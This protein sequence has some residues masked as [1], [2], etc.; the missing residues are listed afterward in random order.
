MYYFLFHW[1][2][3]S[4]LHF[5]P[6]TQPYFLLTLGGF[7][8]IPNIPTNTFTNLC[9]SKENVRKL[10]LST[11]LLAIFIQPAEFLLQRLQSTQSQNPPETSA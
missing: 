2:F 11:L 1:V 3:F 5:S 6:N 4:Y 10:L 9:T 7:L 8:K